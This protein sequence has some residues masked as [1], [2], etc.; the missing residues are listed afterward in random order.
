MLDFADFVAINKFDRSGAEDALRDVRKQVQRN[1]EAFSADARGDAG[2]RHHRRALQRRRRDRALPGAS[3]RS[4]RRRASSSSAGKLPQV[5]GKASSSVHVDRAAGARA[6]P[7]RDRRDACAAITRTRDE[8]ARIARERQQL[9]RRARRC[10]A[11]GK[12]GAELDALIDAEGRRARRRARRSCSTAG[13]RRV[14]GLLGRRVRG[15]DPRPGAAHASSRTTSLSGT[16]VPK[17]A[18]PRYEDAGR[19]PALAAARE[20]A[21]ASSRSPPACSR[22][23]ARTRTRRACSRARATP[24]RTNR[25]FHLLS[26]GHAGEAPVDRVRLRDAVRLRPRRAARHLR[27]GRQLAASRSHARRHE[28]ALL[29]LRPV[30]PDDLGVDDDQRSGADDPRVVL[31][32]RD[33]P[34]GREVRSDN[35]REPTEDELP[36]DQRKDALRPCAARCRPTS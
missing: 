1:R 31:Q 16:Q 23:S 15:E 22:S 30:R 17:V 28:G 18:L 20:P 7:R 3:P 26:Q 6:L 2:V 32:H 13:R 4:C 19:D 36:E 14:E 27:Q 8:Q 21:R 29:G 33:R 5:A 9:E 25:R 12:A 11:G 35:G 34:A 24:D 10:S